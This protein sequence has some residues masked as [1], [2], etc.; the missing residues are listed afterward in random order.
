MVARL[1]KIL[2]SITIIMILF[3]LAGYQLINTK[4]EFLVNFKRLFPQDIKY[5]LKKNFFII[6]DLKKQISELNEK[7]SSLEK[8]ISE[9]EK[10]NNIANEVVFPETQ[11]L[12]LN[13]INYKIENIKSKFDYERYGQIVEP[14]Y[15]DIWNDLLIATLKDGQIFY[16]EKNSLINKKKLNIKKINNNLNNNIEVSDI[17]VLN[18]KLYVMFS[19]KDNDNCNTGN[20]I[21]YS[22][23]LNY[24]ELKFKKEIFIKNN[25]KDNLKFPECLKYAVTAGKM[26]NLKDGNILFSSSVWEKNKSLISNSDLNQNDLLTNK[27]AAFIK[28]DV[29]K[30]TYEVFSIGHRNPIGVQQDSKSRTIIATEHGPRGGDEINIIKKGK[31]YGWPIVSYGEPYG[32][33]PDEPFYYKKNH[34]DNNFQEPV[35]SFIPSIGISEIIEIKENFSQKWKNNYL[36]GSLKKRSLFRIEFDK[37]FSKINFIEQ[38]FIGRRI[39]DMVYDNELNMIFLALE[40]GIPSIGVIYAN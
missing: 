32:E 39:R 23:E 3:F 18:N 22:A 4:N 16:L 28:Y 30:K 6:P 31:N 1:K 11:F 37:S 8:I 19:D 21:L 35:Y 2:L 20:L 34:L 14:F 24:D 26:T 9:A 12:K 38:I 40:D 27:F 15:I 25:G 29:I 17:L 36:I 33:P 10:K 7:N 5:F 13:F